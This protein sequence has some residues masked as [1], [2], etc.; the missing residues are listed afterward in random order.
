MM[1]SPRDLLSSRSGLDEALGGA[2]RESPDPRFL[3]DLRNDLRARSALLLRQLYW[4]D[5]PAPIGS[6]RIVHDGRLV[7]IVTNDPSGFET[8]AQARLG[9]VPRPGLNARVS[10]AVSAVLAGRRRPTEIAYLG[11]L[12]GFQQAVLRAAARIPRGEVRPYAW[13]ARE[14]GVPGAVRAA[15][16]AL[17]HNPV[18]FIVPCHRVV[19]SDWQIGQYSAAGGPATKLRVL[20]SEGVDLDRLDALRV[21][22]VRYVGSRTTNIFC[23]PTC[24]TG[25]HMREIYSVEFR[26]EDQARRAGYRPCLVCRPA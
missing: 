10:A 25:K 23:L 3:R 22:G 26:D 5:L 24:F 9:F 1:T 19:R 2:L 17:A 18:P 16:T 12:G 14:A 7:H 6:L 11:S 15:G 20:R 8:W 21:R 4:F 13:V